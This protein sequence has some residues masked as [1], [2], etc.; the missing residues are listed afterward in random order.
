MHSSK[1][2]LAGFVCNT[3]GEI[4]TRELKGDTSP[5]SQ[6]NTEFILMSTTGGWVRC[7]CDV[8]FGTKENIGISSSGVCSI[9]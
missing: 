4:S 9:S 3:L 6:I 8:Q 5:D 1:V 7:T 2:Y